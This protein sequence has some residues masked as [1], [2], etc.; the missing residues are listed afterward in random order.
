MKHAH[1][2]AAGDES[3]SAASASARQRFRAMSDVLP[4]ASAAALASTCQLPRT[5]TSALMAMPTAGDE[6][7]ATPEMPLL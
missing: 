2:S 1:H 5:L 3:P 6:A 4:D 7:A